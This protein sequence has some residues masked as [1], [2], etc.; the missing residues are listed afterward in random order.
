[1]FTL[2]LLL[3]LGSVEAEQANGR[4]A[5]AFSWQHLDIASSRVSTFQDVSH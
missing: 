5:G 1:M 2:F 3:C 4:L